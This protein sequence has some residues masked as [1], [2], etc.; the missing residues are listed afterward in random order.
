MSGNLV[1]L[2]MSSMALAMLGLVA[3][4]VIEWWRYYK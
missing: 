4:T 2:V 3:V 1:A